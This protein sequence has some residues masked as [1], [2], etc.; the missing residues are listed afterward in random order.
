ME[1]NRLSS[2]AMLSIENNF[3]MNIPDFNNKVID[4]FAESKERRLDFI[5]KTNII[6]IKI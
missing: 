4:L 5:Y 3:I 1:Q 6:K 2:L